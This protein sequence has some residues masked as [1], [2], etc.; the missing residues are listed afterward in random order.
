MENRI[1]IVIP[2]YRHARG[3]ARML[4][5]LTQFSLPVLVVDD[6]NC[7]E[8]AVRVQKSCDE[9]GAVLIRHEENRGKGAAVITGLLRASQENFTHAFQIDADGQHDV[10]AVP[11]FTAASNANPA[12]LVLGTAKFNASIPKIRDKGR[13]ATHIM[14][15]I[16]TCSR[17]IKDSMCGFRIYPLHSILPIVQTSR[18]GHHMEFDIEICVRAHWHGVPVSNLPV[19]VTYP[20]N[21]KSNFRMLADNLHITWMHTRLFFGMLIRLSCAGKRRQTQ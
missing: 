8:D 13:Y 20:S 12:A 1:C 4:A 17:E 16:N 11:Q 21:G 5:Q 14:V 6:G 7:T 3:L 2:V 15:W 19:A 10:S 18:V 9:H